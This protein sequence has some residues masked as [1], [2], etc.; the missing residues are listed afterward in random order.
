MNFVDFAVV[1]ILYNLVQ[2]DLI[3]IFD[4][5]SGS[6]ISFASFLVP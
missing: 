2:R 6:D 3:F 1:K 5:L 4:A